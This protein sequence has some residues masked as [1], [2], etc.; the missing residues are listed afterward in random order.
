MWRCGHNGE[1][2][3]VL[4][5]SGESFIAQEEEEEEEEEE[6]AVLMNFIV[7]F[8][9]R[10]QQFLCCKY[11]REDHLAIGYKRSSRPGSSTAN[12]VTGHT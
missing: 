3:I 2:R 4:G 12:S 11:G 7:L 10:G 1:R 6:V 9:R 5:K 8:E